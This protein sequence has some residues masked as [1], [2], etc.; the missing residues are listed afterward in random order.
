[1]TDPNS[2]NTY[3]VQ[4]GYN[5]YW[6]NGNNEYIG[7]NDAYYNPNTDNSVNNQNWQQLDATDDGG[8]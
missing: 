7:S 4:E 3:K 6:S 5:Q 2:G 8:W 1:M